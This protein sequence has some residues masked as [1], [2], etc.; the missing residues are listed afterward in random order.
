MVQ[1]RL[2]V[3]L[4]AGAAR[5]WAHIG[6][7]QALAERGIV[8]DVVAGCS[9]GAFVG[10]FAAAR[11]LDDL[12]RI[13]LDMSWLETLRMLD[14]RPLQAGLIQ[15]GQVGELLCRHLGEVA[16]EDLPLPFGATTT[17]LAT[18]R[19]RWLMSGPLDAAVRASMAVPGFM[20]P[21]H[22]DGRLLVDG[23]LINPVPISLA[24]ALGADVIIAVA[25]GGELSLDL[26]L[27]G[28][29]SEP[30]KVAVDHL[31][32]ALGVRSVDRSDDRE[33]GF[34]EVVGQAMV[35]VQNF[36]TRVRLAS[37]PADLLLI[38]DMTGIGLFDFHHAEAA[39]AAGRAAVDAAAE[40]IDRLIDHKARPKRDEQG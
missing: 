20:A 5:G 28:R 22:L 25:L 9:S 12:A 36:V 29:R 33:P 15:G 17:E 18:G 34:F 10:A 38:P 2:G 11:R 39:I 21:Q 37:E 19:E 8:P 7:L 1:R 24:K 23:A 6:V 4:G 31:V 14:W 3:A 13:A 16:I 26:A 35:A 32:Q 30:D 40:H 27:E